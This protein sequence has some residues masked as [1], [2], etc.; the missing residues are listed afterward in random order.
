VRLNLPEP[1]IQPADGLGE[2]IGRCVIA[3]TGCPANIF[4]HSPRSLSQAVGQML[5]MGFERHAL[6]RPRLEPAGRHFAGVSFGKTAQLD[7]ALGSHI[8]ITLDLCHQRIKHFMV[9]D[10]A[11][12][13]QIPVRHLCLKVEI[14]EGGEAV[15]QPVDNA[16]AHICGQGVTSL[17]KLLDFCHVLHCLLRSR[18][19]VAW[20][21]QSLGM[22]SPLFDLSYRRALVVG[23]GTGLGR[24]MAL[25]LASAGAHVTVAGRRPEPLN[26]TA[27]EIQAQGGQASAI[28]CDALDPA[29][30]EALRGQMEAEG[31]CGILLYAAGAIQRKPTAEVSLE[32][33]R[34][35]MATNTDGALLCAQALRPLLAAS[36]H[37]RII[38]ITS[39]TSHVALHEVA[40][41]GASKS[42]LLALTRS[43]GCEWGAEGIRVNAISPGVFVTDIN[44]QLLEGTPRGQELRMRT[45]LGRFGLAE[46]VA[47]AAVFFASDAAS[48]ITG[49][50]LPV[51]GGFLASGVNQ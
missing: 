48:F 39:L 46:E 20:L 25:G 1:N 38:F 24:A 16:L 40:A 12:A 41:Y 7:N 2:K 18:P 5:D 17:Q 29:S 30:I 31:G 19:G 15:I 3:Q 33:W 28:C 44:R 37:G 26:E 36:G 11:G 21:C 51:D 22:A 50:C 6:G 9:G 23:G 47:G 49:T 34:R 32:E 4:A 10:E 35:I 27:S 13:S 45:P 42:A 43:L 14:G 8:G